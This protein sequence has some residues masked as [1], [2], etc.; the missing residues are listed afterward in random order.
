MVGT[1][2]GDQIF[3]PTRIQYKQQSRIVDKEFEDVDV[4]QN[5]TYVGSLEQFGVRVISDMSL[6]RFQDLSFSSINN[7]EMLASIVDQYGEVLLHYPIGSKHTISIKDI[8]NACNISLEDETDAIHLK[9]QNRPYI[10][11]KG[12]IISAELNLDNTLGMTFT[13]W[14]F[15]PTPVPAIRYKFKRVPKSKYSLDEVS[16]T[17]NNERMII[18]RHGLLINFRVTGKVARISYWNLM[19]SIF[20]GL[21]FFRIGTEFVSIVGYFLSW[22]IKS[23]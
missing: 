14:L 13:K 10:R 3:V 12:T 23:E 7:M 22:K 20:S 9:S 19:Q 15:E 21:V 18:R 4:P 17:D 11:D 5:E 1:Q 6:D 8:L 2:A 16:E